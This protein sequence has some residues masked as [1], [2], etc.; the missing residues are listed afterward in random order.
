MSI[1][2]TVCMEKP[3]RPRLQLQ[4]APIPQWQSLPHQKQA[5]AYL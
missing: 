3:Y 4:T 2:T 1:W 5:R